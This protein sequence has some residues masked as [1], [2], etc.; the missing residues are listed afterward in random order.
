MTPSDDLAASEEVPWLDDEE[1]SAWRAYVELRDEL[2][3]RLERDLQARSG[4][5]GA[6]YQVL[7]V[8]SESPDDAARPVELCAAMRW[9]QSRLSH[10]LTRMERRG[11]V[12]R[13][14]C[15][16]DG[17]GSIVAL[18]PAG[19]TAIE[20]AAPGHVRALRR[21]L[22][23]PIGREGLLQLGALARR[24]LDAMADEELGAKSAKRTSP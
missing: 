4:L 16:E 3:L 13:R 12:E 22:V 17:R 7:V 5:S 10:Q 9:E 18:T 21:L 19:R 8:L 20:E 11:L 23:D 15:E 14:A 1:Q 6:D 2:T 24:V